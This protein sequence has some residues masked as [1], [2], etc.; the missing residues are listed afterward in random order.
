LCNWKD[1]DLCAVGRNSATP[2]LVHIAERPT[3]VALIVVSPRMSKVFGRRP[4]ITFPII[5]SANSS[6]CWSLV[7]DL[8]F[9]G[10]RPSLQPTRLSRCWRRRWRQPLN[11][12]MC[13]RILH[14]RLLPASGRPWFF[15]AHMRLLAGSGRSA[16][17]RIAQFIT[18]VDGS[19]KRGDRA[20]STVHDPFR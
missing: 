4:E 15:G 20:I 16:P 18:V 6:A 11:P 1:K 17:V 13:A 8:S 2:T 5:V 12:I 7:S 10:L 19:T 3:S 9:R 14:G